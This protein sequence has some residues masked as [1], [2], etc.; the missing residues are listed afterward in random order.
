MAIILIRS[1]IFSLI[2]NI[3][4]R[5]MGKRQ[6]GEIQL[7]EFVSAVLLSE[8]AV[9]PI[10]NTDIPLVHGLMGILALSCLEVISAYLCR[11]SPFARRIVEG[12]ALVLVSEGRIIEKNLTKYRISTDELFAA[13]RSFGLP[14][15]EDVSYV[16]LEQTGAMSVIP[17]DKGSLAHA[18]IVDGRVQKRALEDCGKDARWLNLQLKNRKLKAET[19]LYMTVNDSG[20]IKYA[21]KSGN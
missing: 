21:F 18:V 7:T 20:D 3:T 1:I 6:V 19:L 8:L 13:I 5:L 10:E 2:L 9:L 11:R 4:M 14:G 16:I 12:Q 15:I 17:A